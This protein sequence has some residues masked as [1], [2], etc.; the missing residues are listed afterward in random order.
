MRLIGMVYAFGSV[1]VRDVDA[2][3]VQRRCSSRDVTQ[4]DKTVI[5][6]HA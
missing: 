2:Q 4:R 5:G 6:V 3:V 1:S